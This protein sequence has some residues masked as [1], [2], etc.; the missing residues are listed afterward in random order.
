MSD[1]K[2]LKPYQRWADRHGTDFGV[3][4]W[5]S[6]Q[7]Q[8]ARFAVFTQVAFLHGKRI[9]DA[10]CSRGDFAAYLMETGIEFDEYFGVDALQEVIDYATGRD[11]ERCR[12]VQGDLIHDRAAMKTGNP[13]VICISGTLNTMSDQQVMSVLESAW[14]AT[15]ESLLF[16]FLSDKCHKTAP[17]QDDFARRLSMNMLLDWAFSKTWCVTM[18]QDYFPAGHDA[19]ISMA[20]QAPLG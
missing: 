11:L 9:L 8:R 4:L 15:E 19:T 17:P 3:T 12:F 14:D 2:Y 16:N 7:S 1:E 20:K 13:Q 5:A 18:R 6:P 10:G